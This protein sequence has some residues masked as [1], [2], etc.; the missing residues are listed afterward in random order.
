MSFTRRWMPVSAVLV[1]AALLTACAST[2]SSSDSGTTT[3][4]PGTS[5]RS[6]SG[7]SSSGSASTS[8]GSSSAGSGTAS[9]P[10]TSSSTPSSSASAYFPVK[11]GNTWLYRTNYGNASLGVVMETQR[12]TSVQPVP[13]GQRV[14]ITRSFHYANGRVGDF[15]STA[16][17]V[18]HLDGSL[19][20][21]YQS[22]LTNQGTSV[23]VKSGSIVW[24]SPSQLSTGT[25]RTGT[26]QLAIQTGGRT[27]D[28]SLS[29][30]VQGVG[31][32][33][34]TVPAGSYRAR[35][36]DETLQETVSSVATP[37]GIHSQI[38]TTTGVGLVKSTTNASALTGGS[39]ISTVLMKFTAG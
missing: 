23:V 30:T 9:P 3:T 14:T 7:S 33:M 31:T 1:G 36:L 10:S 22:G 19:T 29:F 17:Y 37:L 16:I 2:K 5:A 4:S 21:P 38:W 8:S 18:S 26:V 25:P 34:V 11:L 6:G 39:T 15:S 32:A 35:V 13:D 28:A 12:I 20:V 24:P 27:V